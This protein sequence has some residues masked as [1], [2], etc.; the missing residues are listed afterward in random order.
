MVLLL[1]M[2]AN[3]IGCKILANLNYLIMK[4]IKNLREVAIDLK[5]IQVVGGWDGGGGGGQHVGC[6][7]CSGDTE[8]CPNDTECREIPCSGPYHKAMT[9]KSNP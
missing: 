7:G 1:T 4:S 2:R 6:V 8:Y 5:A 9:C 3:L